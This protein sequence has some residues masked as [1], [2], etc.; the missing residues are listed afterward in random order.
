MRAGFGRQ[1]VNPDRSQNDDKWHGLPGRMPSARPRTATAAER[2][3]CNASAGARRAP[4]AAAA[5]ACGVASRTVSLVI[6]A[7]RRLLPLSL[8]KGSDHASGGAAQT[9]GLQ[10]HGPVSTAARGL[11]AA[12]GGSDARPTTRHVA[13]ARRP[14]RSLTAAATVPQPPYARDRAC[15]SFQ[16]NHKSTTLWPKRSPTAARVQPDRFRGLLTLRR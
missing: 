8:G 6:R 14:P 1:G 4:L 7:T 16:Y 13:L 12:R 9:Q 3:R 2:R 11:A 10:R 5:A 15:S